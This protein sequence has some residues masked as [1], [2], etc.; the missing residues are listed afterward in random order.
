MDPGEKTVTLGNRFLE[1]PVLCEG[2]EGSRISESVVSIFLV[3]NNVSDTD[4]L[5]PDTDLSFY[6]EWYQS[7]SGS[8]VL[9]AKN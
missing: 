1:A 3:K 5:I 2:I 8:R 6:A 9:L 7:C 4:S